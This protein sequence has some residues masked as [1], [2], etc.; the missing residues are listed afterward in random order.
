MANI[1]NSFS[2]W[3]KGSFILFGGFFVATNTGFSAPTNGFLPLPDELYG[4]KKPS[5]AQALELDEILKKI[6][7]TKPA[8]AAS[9]PDKISVESNQAQ[10]DY[11]ADAGQLHYHTKEGKIQLLTDRGT[12]LASKDIAVDTQ[13]SEAQLADTFVLYHGDSLSI[14]ESGSFNWDT[15]EAEFRHLRTKING[16]IVCAER[17]SYQTDAKGRKYLLMQN[18][19]LSTHDVAK[20]DSWIGFDEMQIYPG[21]HAKLKGLSVGGPDNNIKV[22]VLGWIP[23]S[24]SLNAKEGYLPWIGSKSNWGAYTLNSYG[25]LIGDR[26]VEGGIPISD[27]ILTT[28]VDYRSR[29]GFGYGV[30]FEDYDML[31]KHSNMTGLSLYYIADTNPDINP[32]SIARDEVGDNRYRLALQAMWDLGDEDSLSRKWRFKT[33]INVLSDEY[34]LPDFFEEISEVNDKPDNTVAVTG[35]GKGDE[36]SFVVRFAPNDFYI[37]DERT[38][39]NYYRVRQ[40]IKKSAISYETRNSFGFMRQS[41]PA[42]QLVAYQTALDNIKDEDVANYYRRMMNTSSYARMSSIHEF[43]SSFKALNFL[44]ITPKAGLTY[45]G[46]YDVE[47]VGSE[48][49]AGAFLGCDFDFKFHRKYKSVLSDSMGIDGIT[50]TINPYASLSHNSITS[51]NALI[52]QVNTW[53]SALSGSTNN[54]MPLDL[55]GFVGPDGWSTWTVMR[56]GVQNVL[57]TTYDQELRT[58][59]RWNAFVTINF[60]NPISDNTLSNLYSLL[61][62]NLTQRLSFTSEMQFPAFGPGDIFTE[63]NHSISYQPYS[64]LELQAGLRYLKDHTIQSDANQI[65]TQINIRMSENYSMA[66]RWYYDFEDS[67]MPIQQYSLFRNIGAWQVGATIFLRNNG[68]KHENGFG[69]SFTLRETE[70]AMPLNFY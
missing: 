61:E 64:W 11:K 40:P 70:T 25:F 22:P 6:G 46:Y 65:N 54:P 52:P 60:D 42:D 62:F 55:C 21:S 43:T 32:T 10:I 39:L 59:M 37:A 51:S 47:G 69:L 67:E 57:T 68:G 9:L 63:S 23:L 19:Y 26:R 28:H 36:T 13:K 18:T 38:E 4:S 5:E 1:K 44:N 7:P 34:V 3:L 20:P 30:D 29:R 41:I 31:E 33:N 15:E 14:G 50:H 56:T 17:A 27:Y 16:I 24:H 53:S 2:N 12:E 58:V 35:R 66:M 49:R 8:M 48:N 45:N